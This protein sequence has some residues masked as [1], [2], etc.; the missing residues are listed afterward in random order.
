MDL[1]VVIHT[2]DT[3]ESFNIKALV[4]SGCMG[5]C[6]NSEFVKRN[7]LNTKTLLRVIPVYNADGTLNI[8]GS[9]TEMIQ[10][11]IQVE[12]HF[13]IMDLGVSKLGNSD[14][15]LGHDWLQYHNPEVD[16][17]G[18]TLTFTRCPNTC[19][20][21]NVINKLKEEEE[22]LRTF[23]TTSTKIAIENKKTEQTKKSCQNTIKNIHQCSKKQVFVRSE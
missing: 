13:E 1:P 8:G 12:D 16:W 6:I 4:D 3:L 5:S 22:T 7:N 17:V 19:W 14:L 15:F 18:Q 20:N 9:L 10:V 23:Q 11:K 2:M 21:L